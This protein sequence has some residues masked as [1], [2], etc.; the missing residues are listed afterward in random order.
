MKIQINKTYIYLRSPILFLVCFRLMLMM[1]VVAVVV[2]TVF[3]LVILMEQQMNLSI[4]LMK[5][6]FLQFFH[7]P[8]FLSLYPTQTRSSAHSVDFRCFDCYT[9]QSS[10]A[11]N[12]IL[13]ESEM[14][15]GS[16][17]GLWLVYNDSIRLCVV[18]CKHLMI[19]K[20]NE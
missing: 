6:R 20:L 14:K 1:V 10:D 16:K 11:A 9:R 3:V 4:D 18:G 2:V 12:M 7:S 15:F 5:D 19:Y 8:N 17:C 13:S